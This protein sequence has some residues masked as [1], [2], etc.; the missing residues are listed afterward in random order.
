MA[1]KKKAPARSL[2]NDDIGEEVRRKLYLSQLECRL[3]FA[4]RG[5]NASVTPQVHALTKALGELIQ[6][7]HVLRR[8]LRHAE[9]YQVLDKVPSGRRLQTSDALQLPRV[10]GFRAAGRVP[11]TSLGSGYRSQ[12]SPR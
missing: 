10:S 1:S 5:D 9:G 4:P 12:V 3:F 7:G 2:A 11:C 8:G 6:L